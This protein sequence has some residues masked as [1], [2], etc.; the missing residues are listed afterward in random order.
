MSDSAPPAAEGKGEPP[1]GDPEEEVT[2]FR[3]PRPRS[4][5][6][7]VAGFLFLVGFSILAFAVGLFVFN[8]L[9]APRLIHGNAEIRVPDLANLTLEQAERTLRP[10]GLPLSRAGERFDP[11]VPRGFILSQ[12]PPP[13]VPVRGGRRVMVV[14][15][16][17][18]EFSSV[19]ALFGESVRGAQ[20]LVDRAGLRSG[21][22]TRA[23]FEDVGEGLV[24]GSDPPAEAVMPRE[25]PVALL[26]STGPGAEYYV[27]PDLVGREISRARHQLETFGLRVLTPPAAPTVGPIVFQQPAAGSRITR[28]VTIVLQATGRVL[29]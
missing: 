28:D 26:V 29:R 11:S 19:P 7:R 3:A 16:L 17:G 15:S 10:T 2:P 27:M 18:E 12:D 5:R 25:S 22:V 20:L 23:P 21:G 14:V 6:N 1:A 4:W 8:G 13:D 24:V 9:V